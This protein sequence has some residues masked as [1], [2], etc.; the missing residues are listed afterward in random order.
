[1]H[2][3]TLKEITTELTTHLAGRFLGRV[4]PVSP[5]SL[6]IDFG[7]KSAGFLF[8]SVDPSAPRLYLIKRTSRELEKNSTAH[9]PFTTAFRANFGGGKLLSITLDEE[10]RVL[11][12][13]FSVVDEIGEALSPTLIVQLTGRSSN[14][15]L[16]NDEGR[17]AHA[18]RAP[19]GE[20]QQPGDIYQPPSRH[21]KAI[22]REEPISRGDFST[23][24][25]ALDH[26]YRQLEAEH[27]F[28]G[29]AGDLIR[30][31]RKEIAR[32]KKLKA[33]LQ[34]DLVTHGD[35]DQHKRMGD[36]LLANISNAV[37]AGNLVKLNDYYAQ[38]APVIEI[39]VDENLS[40]QDAAGELFSRYAKAKRAIEEVGARLTR[41]DVELTG[42]EEKLSRLES[43]I[44]RRDENALAEFG[45]VKPKAAA[46]SVNR[47]GK[48]QDSAAAAGMRRY[49][50]SDG[51]E[52]LVG[53]SARDND[54]LTFK[55]ARPNDLWLHAG[56]YPGSHVIIR[57]SSKKAIPQRTVIEAA[58]LAAK[59]SQAGKDS[60]VTIHYTPR[61]FISKPKGG[62]PGL[63]RMSNFKSITVEPGETMER[64]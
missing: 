22:A 13:S 26:H 19:R 41:T 11:R 28:A 47:K 15:F 3:E 29:R 37:R 4:F 64:V 17:I 46:V 32:R 2:R 60:K 16:L 21:A 25:A 18:F 14:L 7:L 40:L 52:V 33:N 58:Q 48:P 12:F 23:V 63:V 49:K 42:L 24:S 6:A 44:E 1:M 20:G 39:E 8:V 53:R 55:V 34:Q 57:N 59:F 45:E 56:D 50:S 51:Y 36:L 5:T 27:D 10:E 30:K 35:P 62:A 31:L 43:A 61:K 38:G 54:Q 9:S